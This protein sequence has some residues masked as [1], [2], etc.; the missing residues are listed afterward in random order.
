[1]ASTITIQSVVNLCSIHGDLLPL[2]GIGGYTNEPALSLANDALSEI[3]NT[4]HDW[5][6]NRV[7]LDAHVQ[8]LVTAPR[9]Q[10]YLF[11]GA[12]AFTLG[13]TSSGAA[14]DLA[15]SNAITVITGVVTVNTLETHR[16]SVGDTVY[17]LGNKN[18]AYNST[19]TDNGSSSA[20]SGG[21]V[22]TAVTANSFSFA[23]TTGQTNGDVTGAPGITDYGWLS[24]GTMSQIN[25]D[26]SPPEIIPI[27]AVRELPA[28]SRVSRPEKVCVVTDLGTGVIKVRFYGVPGTTIWAVNLV[29]QKAAPVKTALSQTWSPIP[30]QYSA[31]FRQALLYRMYR[32][33]N[34]P[35]QMAELQKLQQE[36]LKALGADNSETSDVYLTPETPLMDN[37]AGALYF[38]YIL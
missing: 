38:P 19:Y 26:A 12:S 15:S 9:K 36:I 32:Y 18:A 5:K 4:P 2:T 13:A 11:A 27:Q 21:W 7:E 10:D 37:S 25:T 1:M 29:Y 8:P 22:I 35:L 6:W 31:L 16:F 17:T 3:I 28:W 33:I 23:A 20:F 14:I 24:S 30:D 34:S